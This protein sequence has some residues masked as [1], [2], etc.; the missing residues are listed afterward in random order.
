M[1]LSLFGTAIFAAGLAGLA[2]V[3]YLLQ[4]LR[5]RHREVRVPTT[6]FWREAV[7]ESR[8]RIFVRRFRHPW[9]YLLLWT[10]CALLWFA[11]AMPR[12]DGDPQ[13]QHLLVLDGS[14]GMLRGTSFEKAVH[15]V[16]ERASE[17]PRARTRVVW[18]GARPL[19]LLAPGEDLALLARRVRDFRPEASPSSLS[20]VLRSVAEGLD[21]DQ[22]L[23]VEIHGGGELDPAWAEVLPKRLT[24]RRVFEEGNN[25]SAVEAGIV[26]WGVSE[27]ASGRWDAV[28]LY[29]RVAGPGAERRLVLRGPQGEVIPEA[30]SRG[31]EVEYWLRDVSARGERWTASLPADD[32]SADD[33]AELLLPDRAPLRMGLSPLV[34]AAA[35]A[36]LEADS[37]VQIVDADFDVVLRTQEETFGA[38]LPALVLVES[39]A[40]SAAFLVRGPV[41]GNA[42]QE[43]GRAFEQLG[44]REVDALSLAETSRRAIE[45]RFEEDAE[46]RSL[47]VWS[48]LL[49]PDYDFVQTRAFPLFLAAAVRWLADVPELQQDASAGAWITSRRAPLQASDGT[50]LDGVGVPFRLPRV[51]N[52]SDAQG[53]TLSVALLDPALHRASAPWPSSNAEASN[54]LFAGEL[55]P[56]IA[57][58]ALLLLAAEWI[59]VRKEWIP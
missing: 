43:L 19:T 39:E 25:P 5:V 49:G 24:V 52:W 9:A 50:Q 1:S 20:T 12:A 57:L 29:A 26:A 37:G 14:A 56:W 27:S 22:S 58:L 13:L 59:F 31:D 55:W 54:T 45:L 7:E 21:P 15:S 42:E 47:S 32:F 46:G 2:G 3:L 28:D 41:D 10:I 17:L 53:S 6:L 33:Q 51:G 4:R 30:F 34:P 11:T 40:D 8:A 36:V 35:R 48:N 18:A 38:G 44:L 23:A 16:L